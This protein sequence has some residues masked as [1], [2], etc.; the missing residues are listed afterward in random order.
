MSRFPVRVCLEGKAQAWFVSQPP[1][2]AP[3]RISKFQPISWE[4]RP[5]S[6][7]YPK[8]PPSPLKFSDPHILSILRK[9]YRWVHNELRNVSFTIQYL[10]PDLFIESSSVA[11]L[12]HHFLLIKLLL[13]LIII[14][15]LIL[16]LLHCLGDRLQ[17]VLDLLLKLSKF[18]LN[19][20]SHLVDVVLII[21][22]CFCWKLGVG[23]FILHVWKN[24]S[25]TYSGLIFCF[26]RL[27][28]K[29]F[30]F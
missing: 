28:W 18:V 30:C 24:M 21:L 12:V 23:S 19:S 14:L 6:H 27:L 16:F 29:I 7:I 3:T 9:G 17:V 2:R 11:L 25:G 8:I 13:L 5:L 26:N 4:N 22:L 10:L 15:L 20:V 1:F